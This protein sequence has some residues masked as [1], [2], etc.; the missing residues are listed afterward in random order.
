MRYIFLS[1]IFFF[2]ASIVC[3]QNMD[4][5]QINKKMTEIRR[6]TNWDDP[7]AAKKAN[8]EIKKL[9]KQLKL[10]KQNIDTKSGNKIDEIKKENVES[11][12]KLWDQ[13]MKS[14][15]KGKDADLLLGEPVREEII[16]EYKDDESPIIK[17]RNILMR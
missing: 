16:E 5:K 17:A 13:M 11:N 14:F 4:A 15:E 8:E 10:L 2:A 12:A 3:A 6:N 7:A 1:L 9:S